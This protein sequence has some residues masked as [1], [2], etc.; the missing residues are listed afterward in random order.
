MHIM[1]N[2]ILGRCVW[3]CP[4]PLTSV[5]MRQSRFEWKVPL[6]HPQA[7]VFRV[8]QHTE[9]PDPTG[10]FNEM[11][12]KILLLTNHKQLIYMDFLKMAP[13]GIAPLPKEKSVE[14]V[15]TMRNP[16]NPGA[17]VG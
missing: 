17:P 12:G 10:S 3:L 9:R 6:Q 16:T 7:L 13:N 1:L 15:M 4:F 8:P 5:E 14:S 11:N 2:V